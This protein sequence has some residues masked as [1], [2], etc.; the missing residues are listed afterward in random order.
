M[1]VVEFKLKDLV[2]E[3][4][5]CW[6]FHWNLYRRWYPPQTI[7]AHGSGCSNLL[8]YK[9]LQCINVEHSHF[10]SNFILLW[11]RVQIVWLSQKFNCA[12]ILQLKL[13]HFQQTLKTFSGTTFLWNLWFFK[14]ISNLISEKWST[15]KPIEWE[16]EW[17]DELLS[18]RNGTIER[19]INERRKKNSNDIYLNMMIECQFSWN[20]NFM[21]FQ[22]SFPFFK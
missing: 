20:C 2:L 18:A 22:L 7:L 17:E 19:N 8:F 6:Y 9:L 1:G 15:L 11:V 10:D 13:E 4:L 16:S 12:Q 5:R 14:H 21:V 3:I